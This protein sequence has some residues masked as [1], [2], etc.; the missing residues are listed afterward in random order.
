VIRLG[1][2]GAGRW[3][4]RYIQTVG[5]MEGVQLS[6]IT[7]NDEHTCEI[8]P[9][10]CKITKSWLELLDMRLDGIIIASPSRVQTEIALTAIRR[11]MPVLLQKP[12]ALDAQGA[13]EI[14]AQTI[15]NNCMVVVDHT[16]VFNPGYLELKRIALQLGDSMAINSTGGA[17][18]PFDRDIPVLWDWGPHD[19]AM[20]LDLAGRIPESI[21]AEKITKSVS[22]GLTGEV[23][24]AH[25]DF[26]HGATADIQFGNIMEKK[27]RCLQVVTENSTVTYDDVSRMLVMESGGKAR[28]SPVK[29][30]M[31]LTCVINHFVRGIRGEHNDL[32]TLNLGVDVVKTLERIDQVIPKNT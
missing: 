4:K 7:S 21:S 17:C 6:M 2:I 1:L 11:G 29:G 14:Q 15:E 20:S 19:V 10:G 22:D 26:G 5:S 18:G 23:I 8:A 12:L 24:K 31:P 16:Q 32:G 27:T 25:L 9:V 28:K 3:G 30:A 13:E